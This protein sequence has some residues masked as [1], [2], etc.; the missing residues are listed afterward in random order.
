MATADIETLS[1]PVQGMTC[2]S[3]VVRVEKTLTKL[4]GVQ[5]AN[6]NLATEKATISY[7]PAQTS[8]ETLARA[9]DEAGYKLILPATKP[10]SDAPHDHTEESRDVLRGDL[11][12]SIILTVPIMAVSMLMMLPSFH[13][14]FPVGH[15]DTNKLLLVV[16]SCV[17]FLPGR[18][19][20]VVAWKLARRFSADMNTLVAVGTGTAYVYSVIA[21]LFPHWL[22]HS[23]AANHV[24]FDTSATIIT[25]IVLGKYLEASAKRRASDAIRALLSLQPKTARVIRNGSEQ[26]VTVD[27]VRIDD[28]VLVRPG[29]RIPV[30]GVILRGATTLDESMVTGESLPVEKTVG[31]RVVGGTINKNGSVEFRA[32][33]VG[34][35]TFLAHIARMVE[36]AQGSKAPVQRLADTIAGVFVP[37]VIGIA[38]V[39]FFAWYFGAQSTFVEAMINFIAV[40]IIACPCALGLA[41]PTAIM[42]GTGVGA[43]HGILFRNAET[44]EKAHQVRTVVIDKTGTLTQGRPTVTDVIPADTS[45]KLA[46]NGM[47]CAGWTSEAVLSLAA[48]AESSSEHPL[49]Q[50]IVTAAAEQ[51]L[52]SERGVDFQSS[53]G[54]GVS[55]M[56]AGES[57]LAGSPK[58]LEE[59]GI[60]VSAVAESLSKL[61]D[62]AK[63]PIVVAQGSEVV[64]VIGISDAIKPTSPEAIEELRGMD[65]DVVLATGDNQQ[66]AEAVARTAGI[67]TVLSGILPGEKARVVKDLQKGGKIVAMVGDGINDAPALAQADVGM[68]MGNGTDVALE[69]ADIAL[70]KNDLRGI[71]AAFRLSRRTINTIRQNLFWAF[72][73]NVVGIPLAA[74]GLMNPVLAAAAMAFSSVSVISNSLRLRSVRLG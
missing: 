3:C 7:D 11:L 68:A 33:A 10:V 49:A 50:A 42:V 62:A 24:Y 27:D 69:A 57:I 18:R 16:A 71:A 67:R 8:L 21:V 37:V 46:V 4:D 9:V 5:N 66:T 34:N 70:T 2:A 19:F 28:V 15:D 41:T 25:L 61:R 20:F 31:D 32:T 40:L 45:A 53:P 51:G 48:A 54:K 52:L 58:F 55:A 29:E 12:L 47:S 26:D 59:H 30:D 44:L 72:I 13:D 6:V 39:T 38:L 1:L 74:F 65:I 23:E 73:Y 35:D 64:G 22:G 36:D 60:D 17:M 56:I 43:R 14:W 63:T